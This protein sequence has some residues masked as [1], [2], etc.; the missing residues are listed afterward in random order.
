MRTK[1]FITV[2]A[3]IITVFIAR[4]QPQCIQ[5]RHHYE[6]HPKPNVY[7]VTVYSACDESRMVKVRIL[8]AIYG[9]MVR[10]EEFP[11]DPGDTRSVRIE[12]SGEKFFSYAVSSS[13]MD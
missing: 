11:L 7:V 3:L 10:E 2:A 12:F 5:A 8:E 9:E 4:A 6:G 13:P 1:I